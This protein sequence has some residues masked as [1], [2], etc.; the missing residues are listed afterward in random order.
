MLDDLDSLVDIVADARPENTRRVKY[1]C[2]MRK[3]LRLITVYADTLN[4]YGEDG[5]VDGAY[6]MLEKLRVSWRNQEMKRVKD[7][8][9]LTRYSL[10]ST[11]AVAAVT[12]GRRLE[13]V[14]P[15]SV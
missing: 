1:F 6:A 14:S 5:D 11:E 9:E 13:Q 7:N 3:K 2:G 4:F 12:N 15:C 10:P 8:L